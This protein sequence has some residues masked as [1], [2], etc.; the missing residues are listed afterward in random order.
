MSIGPSTLAW[1][2]GVAIAFAAGTAWQVSPISQLSHAQE[3]G[4][5]A[6]GDKL[7]VQG[8]GVA[9][10]SKTP[11]GEPFT[12]MASNA[13]LRA[14]KVVPPGKTFIL[15][16]MMYNARGVRQDLTVNL[17]HGYEAMKVA[18]SVPKAD[19]L[20]QMY[21]KPGESQETHLCSGYV[22]PSGHSVRAWTNAGLEPDQWVQIAVTGYLID[23]VRP[24]L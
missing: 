13:P 14:F 17:A 19:I 15:T 7:L 11:P 16:D 8:H 20:L 12:L 9:S 3:Q 18:G 4:G 10:S 2:L 6:Q 23:E 1:A 5:N 24:S 21:L 22:I